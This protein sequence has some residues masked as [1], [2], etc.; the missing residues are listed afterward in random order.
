[1]SQF[2]ASGGQIMGAQASVSVIPVNIQ[3]WFPLRLTGLISLQSKES[4]ESSP[5]PQFKSI[6]SSVL[7]FLYCPTCTSVDD[8]W[9][10]HSLAR[11]TFVGKVM[12]LLFNTLSRFV[13]AL[14]PR[15]SHLNSWLQSP[16]AVILDLKKK[17]SVTASSLS[18]S[19]E[20]HRCHNLKCFFFFQYWVLNQLFHCLLSPSS[21]GSLMPLQFCL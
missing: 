1:M 14:L 3:G 8:H 17:K 5:T 18:P 10:N 11:R 12:S 15:S 19:S 13:I 6:S 2:F 7:S 20:G 21:R 9:K 16:S 4:Q